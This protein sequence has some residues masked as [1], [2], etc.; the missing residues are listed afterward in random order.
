MA[1]TDEMESL[2]CVVVGAGE[3]TAVRQIAA[4]RKR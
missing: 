2:D 3:S 1:Q 4:S